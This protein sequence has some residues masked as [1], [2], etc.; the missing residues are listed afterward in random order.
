MKFVQYL[1]S[2]ACAAMMCT[3][4]AQPPAAD[5][6]DAKILSD[7]ASAAPGKPFRVGVLFTMKPDWHIYWKN[8]GESGFETSIKWKANPA[9]T[10]VG[11]LQYPAPIM[12]EM[13]GPLMSF[14]Y[15]KEVLLF[16]E[17]TPAADA[18]EV[19]I[20]ADAKWLMCSDRCIPGKK[21]LSVK[22]PVGEATPAN[23]EIFKKY[24][25]Q[26]PTATGDIKAQIA[27]AKEGDAFVTKV[28]IDPAGKQILA[29]DDH[30][31]RLYFFPDPLKGYV[32]EAPVVSKPDGQAG[33]KPAYTKPA[34]V[35]IKM[36]PEQAGGTAPKVSG[37]V[38]YQLAGGEPK[39]MVVK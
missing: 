12:F 6:V 31:H 26:V 22:I 35:T 39:A 14:G 30:G 23:T 7:A 25:A 24:A 10:K 15:A 20:S 21:S 36:T 1:L 32:P 16:A 8:P 29:G 18:K 19:E 27:T 33:G 3:A 11:E 4:C 34:T 13:P 9:S 5:F 38:T 2:A 37:V 17:V 28:T